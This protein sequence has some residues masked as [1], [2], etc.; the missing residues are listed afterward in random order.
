MRTIT[1]ILTIILVLLSCA[2]DSLKS[3]GLAPGDF[4]PKLSYPLLDGTSADLANFEGKIVL[5]N[6]W[7]SW[8]GPCILELPA[9]ERLHQRF[10]ERGFTVL[11]VGIDDTRDNLQEFVVK[12]GLTFPVMNDSSGSSKAQYRLTGVP[13]TLLIDRKGKIILFVDPEEKQP[14]SKVTGPREW[15]SEFFIKQIESL[16][17]K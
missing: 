8:C 15:D 1:R 17:T 13:E 5:V 16:L 4:A 12:Y 10:K 3:R 2:C 6:F 9:L 7:A 11:G 14:T